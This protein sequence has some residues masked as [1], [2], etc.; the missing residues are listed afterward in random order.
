MSLE[1]LVLALS[2]LV[3]VAAI[4]LIRK[5]LNEEQAHTGN[6]GE[7]SAKEQP[8]GFAE[9]SVYTLAR[10]I[11]A[12]QVEYS[13]ACVRIKVLLDSI[14]QRS[15]WNIDL[16]VFE[17]VYLKLNEHP[18]RAARADMSPTE[19]LRWDKERWKIEEEN[20]EAIKLAAKRL[21]KKLSV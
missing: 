19:R 10:T 15:E 14:P 20:Q 1:W 18:T 8:L 3:A 12:D 2:V 4:F 13:E 9:K 11:V 5:V 17:Q 21:I 16:S 6:D 7:P